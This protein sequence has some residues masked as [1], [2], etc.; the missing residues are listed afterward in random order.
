[1]QITLMSEEL[2][3]IG[4]QLLDPNPNMR[5]QRELA[6]HYIVKLFQSNPGNPDTM[7]MMAAQF[8]RMKEWGQALAIT[9]PGIVA[10]PAHVGLLKHHH[11][12]QQRLGDD[13]GANNTLQLLYQH[14][15]SGQKIKAYLDSQ[16][17]ARVVLG[18][19]EHYYP[20]WLHLDLIPND[21]RIAWFDARAPLWL[22]EASMDYVFSEHMIEHIVYDEGVDLLMDIFRVL[23]P[24]GRTRIATPDLARTCALAAD[25]R[26]VTQ[27][28]Y[29]NF[30]NQ[31][32]GGDYNNR[33]SFVINNMFFTY[34]HAFVYDEITLSE[35]MER[36][37]FTNITRY[38][39]RSSDTPDLADKEMHH[40][41]GHMWVEDYQ[42]LVLEATKPG[43]ATQ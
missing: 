23:K 12:I 32:F 4:Q 5:N 39:P 25:T 31:S 36:A 40:L 24:G 15:A 19:G 7:A 17:V 22:P 9:S 35:A 30:I 42:T 37:G 28:N 16:P 38:L 10:H 33:A 1:M 14:D 6:L 21:N 26:N 18:P 20:G 8:I 11:H 2:L 3:A 27:Q 43:G 41:L 29:V 34:N 13:R